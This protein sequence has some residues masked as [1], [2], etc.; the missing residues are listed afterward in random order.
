MTAYTTT[1]NDALANIREA[2][3][4]HVNDYDLDAIFDAIYSYDDAQGG[5]VEDED[6][7]FWGIVAANDLTMVKAEEEWDGEGYYT[8]AYTDGGMPFTS[9]GAIWCDYPEDLAAIISG[10]NVDATET[11]LPV[12]YFEG[13]EDP[14]EL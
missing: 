3:D 9:D 5:F 13:D 10:A 8:V 7:D 11:H 1:K 6:A 12:V 2:L 4:E 14:E